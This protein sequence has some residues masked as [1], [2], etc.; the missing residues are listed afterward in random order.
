MTLRAQ[1]E[2]MRRRFDAFNRW[3]ETQ[4][5]MRLSP[6]QSVAAMGSLWG[7]LSPDVRFSDPDPEKRGLA[8]WLSALARVNHE[9][10]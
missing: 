8:S 7:L 6:E 10:V 3:E 9:S 1:V 4:P 2:E 5:P